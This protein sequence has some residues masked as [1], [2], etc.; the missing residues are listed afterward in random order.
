MAKRKRL[1]PAAL[2][3]ALSGS[4]THHDAPLETKAQYPMG[5]APAARTRAPIAQV[6]GEAAA[7]AALSEVAQELEAARAGGRLVQA[8]AL[9]QVRADHLLRDRMG[10]D[11]E[12]MAVL[13]ASLSARGQQTPI[14][15]V[16]LEG[17]G[18]GLVSGWRRLRALGE[19]LAETGEDRFATV[20]A[21]IKPLEGASD[22]YVAM[23]E[24]N[25]IRANLSFYERARLACEAA[26]LGVYPT[27]E[28][29]V[30]TLFAHAPSAKRSK[31]KSFIRIHKALGDLLR[32]PAAIPERVGLALSAALEADGDLVGRVKAAT[33]KSPP[34]D[35]AAER[36]LI[37]QAMRPDAPAKPAPAKPELIPGVTVE[38]GRNRV[39]LS[40]PGVTPALQDALHEWLRARAE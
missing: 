8:L 10:A 38:A 32:F 29:A 40:G 12:E 2:T 35:A 23:V 21:L 20:Q 28:R 26:R 3:G 19:L 36:K 31:I 5:V 24:E 11:A 7:Q 15:V 14:E 30:Q 27:P 22:S 39:L 9:D 17:G 34:A 4:E 25:E 16:A 37:E 13:K 33:R 6:A 1:T 18:Y